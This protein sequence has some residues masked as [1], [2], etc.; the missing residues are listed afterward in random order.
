M[1]L[2]MMASFGPTMCV[3]GSCPSGISFKALL[4]TSVYPLS[5]D[6]RDTLQV[7]SGVD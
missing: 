6:G 7:G 5:I 3:R 1:H 4:I 2:F